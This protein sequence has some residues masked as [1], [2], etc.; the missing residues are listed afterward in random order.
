MARSILRHPEAEAELLATIE[1]YDDEAE[2]S[3]DFLAEVREFSARIAGAPESFP[4]APEIDEVRRARLQRF[5]YWLVFM[6]DTEIFI[7]AMAHVRRE[8]G[9]WSRRVR[10]EG[11]EVP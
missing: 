7:L 2:L 9:Y 4:L 11:G 5:P 6:Q 3:A 8:P 10:D 1:W